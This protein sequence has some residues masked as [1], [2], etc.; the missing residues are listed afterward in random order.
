MINIV[1]DAETMELTMEGHAGAAEKGKDIVCSAVSTMFYTLG[2]A[3]AECTEAMKGDTV[4]DMRDG[5]GR[6]KCDPKEE[7]AGVIQ[8]IYWTI[9]IGIEKIAETYPKFVSFTSVRG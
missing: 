7:C 4:I 9:L 6:I 2:Y 1:F 3:L 5:Y 8:R